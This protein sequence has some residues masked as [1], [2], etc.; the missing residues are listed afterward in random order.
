M[1]CRYLSKLTIAA[2]ISLVF[3]TVQANAWGPSA[4]KAIVSTAFQVLDQLYQDPFKSED[5]SYQSDVIRGAMADRSKVISEIN[6]YD[7]DAVINAIGAEMLLLRNMAK[8]GVDSYFSYRMGVL[9]GLVSDACLPF[10]FDQDPE[11]KRLL[12]QINADIDAHLGTYRL[13]SRP[14]QLQYVTNFSS[15]IEEN[16]TFL[17]DAKFMIVSDYEKGDGYDGYMREGGQKFFEGAVFAVAHVWYTVMRAHG[18]QRLAIETQVPPSDAAVTQYLVKEIEYQIKEKKNLTE[19]GKAYD[20]LAALNLRDQSVYERVGDAFYAFDEPEARERAVEEWDAALAMNG[21]NRKR[22]MGKLSDHYLEK[23]KE[24]FDEASTNPDA[25]SATLNQALVAFTRALEY[26]RSSD[27]AASLI[28]NTQVAISERNERQQMAIRIVASGEAVLREAETAFAAEQ[29][30]TALALYDK[31][32]LVLGQVSPEFK[33]QAQ[34]AKDG[35]ETANRMISR[36]IKR[37]LDQAQDQID[38]G[39]RL[40]EDKKFDDGVSRYAGVETILKVVP[41]QE[42]PDAEQKRKLIEEAKGKVEDAERAKVQY[43]ELQKSQA[44]AAAQAQ[45]AR[46]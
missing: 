28:S 36:I 43:D 3:L 10:S 19:A 24:L 38:E 22:I 21:P 42:G 20:Q 6:K 31:A 11:G 25:P 30:E 44:A 12:A 9:A 34:A 5:V 37:V 45:P 23:G 26:D 4:Q 2:G 32:V 15:Y 33:E 13:A 17:Q 35:V 16:Q 18:T 29:N 39:D 40:V 8:Q 14:K 46:R 1:T 27:D 41:D 7:R